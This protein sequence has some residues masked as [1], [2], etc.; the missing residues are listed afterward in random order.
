M[1]HLSREDISHLAIKVWDSV[2]MEQNEIKGMEHIQ[3]CSECERKFSRCLDIL[4]FMSEEN[5]EK[6][7]VHGMLQGEHDLGV[8]K[9]RVD[10]SGLLYKMRFVADQISEKVKVIFDKMAEGLPVFECAENIAFARGVEECL[11]IAADE[12]VI[13]YDEEEELL[14]V[15]L[16]AE[17]FK[18]LVLI[19]TV[20][21]DGGEEKKVLVE[22]GFGM[23]EAEFSGVTGKNIE[24]SI[25][26]A[27][28]EG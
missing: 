10:F 12:S 4:D 16:E 23:L 21:S 3:K 17:K 19:A 7:F 11:E 9:E 5:L 24:L 22:D 27:E 6:Y 28:D 15:S 26:E 8:A 20:K 13:R 18:G 2:P 1:K 14:T 25:I